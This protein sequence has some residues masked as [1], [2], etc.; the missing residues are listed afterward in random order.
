MSRTILI[1]SATIFAAIVSLLVMHDGAL[2]PSKQS[3]PNPTPSAV[4][5]ASSTP[6]PTASPAPTPSPTPQ[7]TP[8]PTPE[9]ATPEARYH[10][11]IAARDN[12]ALNEAVDHFQRLIEEAGPLAPFARLR[13][14]QALLAAG[15]YTDAATAFDTALADPDLP[16]IF[17]P[18]ALTE[19]AAA[20]AADGRA[21]EAIAWLTVARNHP[22]AS[23][24]ERTIATW[25]RALIRLDREDPLWIADALAV[26]STA[27]GSP[28]AIAALIALDE[29]APE[30]TPPLAAAYSQYRARENQDATDRYEAIR[31][32]AI[33]DGDDR[34][35]GIAAFYLGA[36]AERIAG[37]VAAID[38]YTQSLELDPTGSS[39][40]DAAY[41]RGRVAEERADFDLA[42]DSYDL[43]L[44][45]YPSSRFVADAT[46]RAALTTFLAN[47]EPTGL[48]LLATIA[49][50]GPGESNGTNAAAA[51]W[52]GLLA[53][54]EARIAAGLPA[55]A[56]LDPRSLGAV[57]ATRSPHSEGDPPPEL[58][59]EPLPTLPTAE[60]DLE[61]IT[62]WLLTRF[63]ANLEATRAATTDTPLWDATIPALLAAGERSLARALAIN[64][65]DLVGGHD[66]A[67]IAIALRAR[68]LG[69]HDVALI[70]TL[71]VIGSWSTEERLRN[72]AAIERLTYPSPWTTELALAT[73]EFG[74]P[75]LLLL[76]LVRQESAFNPEAISPAAAVGLTQVI[77]Q[78]G[79]LIAASLDEPWDGIQSLTKPAASL[80]YGA[81]YLATQLETFDYN[82]Y[83]ALA[84][85]NGGPSNSKRWLD[86]QQLPDADGFVQTIDFEETRRY[87][88]T[89][90]E[91]FAW[92]R[93]VYGL[94]NTPSLP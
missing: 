13:L 55:A 45:S 9:P 23:S 87:V 53:G 89:V 16:A 17:Q 15:E 78:T 90:I 22:N 56:D 46:L 72:P 14:A 24:G 85:Y 91:Q 19:G 75:P 35:A 29:H 20:L 50:S 1:A 62:A 59:A 4:V 69:L 47:D 92:Y 68:E 30:D 71:R 61:V 88:A 21:S 31:D 37:R 77:P 8:S 80:R 10:A 25:D 93:Y 27:P 41:W 6:S 73:T 43:L 36:L 94:A 49:Q 18:L 67:E 51:R 11:A 3:T 5:A 82:L 58:T 44:T 70:A 74:I 66:A 83:A 32:N 38:H 39:A 48:A 84:A 79:A 33:D 60:E 52:Y 12:G 34:T 76:A 81:A 64:A 26:L 63:G 54:S 7:P 28:Q 40:D 42:A 2:P 65:L 57:L 86:D